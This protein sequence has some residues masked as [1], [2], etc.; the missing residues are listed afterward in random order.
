MMQ[1][2][3]DAAHL[4]TEEAVRAIKKF[5]PFN[6]SHEGFAVLWEEVDEL[7]DAV[8]SNDLV[9]ARK[10]AVQVAAMALRFIAEVP[11]TKEGTKERA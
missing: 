4:A 11:T 3:L 10:E 7:W 1:G 9:A 5:K 6:S 8:K 2:I